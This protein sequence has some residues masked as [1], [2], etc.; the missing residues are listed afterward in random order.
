M[1]THTYYQWRSEGGGQGGQLPMGAARR[2]APKSCQRIKKKLHWEI[3]KN[4]KEYNE[5]VVITF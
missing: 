1:L 2:G 4:L 5:N 3:F